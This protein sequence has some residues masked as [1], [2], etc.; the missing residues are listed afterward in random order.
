MTENLQETVAAFHRDHK[1]DGARVIVHRGGQ[2]VFDIT[3]GEADGQAITPESVWW[4]ASMT[5]PAIALAALLLVDEGAIDLDDEVSRFIPEFAAARRVRQL[6]AGTSLQLSAPFDP[7]DP[8][9]WDYV[10]SHGPLTVRHFLTMTSGLQTIMVSNPEIPPVQPDD[11]LQSFVPR[12][13]HAALD[14]QPGTRW[15]YS[16][17]T[18][19]EVLARIVEVASG[20]SIADVVA[21]RIFIPLGMDSSTFGLTDATRDRSL[22]LGF[23]AV[24]PLVGPHFASGSA[25]LFS[26]G[27]DYARFAE[28]LLAARVGRASPFP[29]AVVAELA[30]NQIGDLRLGGVAAGAYG[31]FPETTNA[32]VG[33]GFGV[34]TLLDPEVA[35]V[36]LPVGS[37]GWD[38]I[39]SRRFWVSPELDTTIVML[40]AGDES[41]AFH[42]AVESAVRATH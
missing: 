6:A 36:D 12:L 24:H 2:P 5:K 8:N 17:A 20:A 32:G 4:I 22:P 28:A 1:I 30:R 27:D 35:G 7:N 3:V 14:F 15:H 13:G 41:D 37:F 19:Y 42:R 26:T 21:Q 10:D 29:A 40:V 9:T 18:G 16:N 31:A 34:L 38:G 23:I 39:G 11:T 33:Y 25:G